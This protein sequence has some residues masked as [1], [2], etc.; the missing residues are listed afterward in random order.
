MY[1]ASMCQMPCLALWRE[2]NQCPSASLI[3]ERDCRNVY[4]RLVAIWY[5]M[6]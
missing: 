4:K 6:L 1:G 2:Q 5:N 3:A